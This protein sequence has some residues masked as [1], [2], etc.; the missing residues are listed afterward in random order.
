V[1]SRELLA[2]GIVAVPNL[3]ALLLLDVP[4]RNAAVIALPAA[5]PTSALA[6]T[7]AVH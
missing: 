2:F 4:R 1:T 6:V 3:A 5:D 7:H